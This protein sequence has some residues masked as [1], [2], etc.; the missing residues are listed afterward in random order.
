MMSGMEDNPHYQAVKKLAAEE[1]AEC[2]PICAKTEEDI[3][4]Y[5]PEEDVY[6]RQVELV[7]E[8]TDHLPAASK[9]LVLSHCNCQERA[10]QLKKAFLERCAVFLSLIHI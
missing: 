8:E 7:A 9:L 2:I 4:D 5:T 10:M 6:K 3:A 1:G